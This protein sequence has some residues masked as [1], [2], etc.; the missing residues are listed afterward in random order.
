MGYMNENKKA[1]GL[2]LVFLAFYS[3]FGAFNYL[4]FGVINNGQDFLAHFSQSQDYLPLYNFVFQFFVFDQLVFYLANLF[5]ILF[6]IPWLLLKISSSFYSVAIY[7]MGVSLPHQL[8]YGATYPSAMVLV[9][10]LVYL[11]YKRNLLLLVALGLLAG[12]THSKGIYLFGLVFFAEMAAMAFSYRKSLAT[13]LLLPKTLIGL[14]DLAQVFFSFT[15]LPV[16]Y[17]ALKNRVEPFYLIMILFSFAATVH[18]IRAIVAAQLLLCILAGR[19]IEGASKKVRIGFVF[20]LL[21]QLFFYL[22]D[23]AG[24]TLKFIVLN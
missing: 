11:L 16:V 13:G 10:L 1:L 22:L 6:L 8:L 12:L 17:F 15:P 2:I 18:E 23:F 14:K 21:A 24:G 20:F 3:L 5:V 7:L 19:N 9:F 4:N